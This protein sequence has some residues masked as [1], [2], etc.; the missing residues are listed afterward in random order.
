MLPKQVKPMES[1]ADML[2]ER[3]KISEAPSL[4]FFSAFSID[5]LFGCR[6]ADARLTN[7][8]GISPHAQADFT[9]EVVKIAA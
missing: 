8:R 7:I 3:G 5:R 9:K 2:N 4:T 1:E 6:G